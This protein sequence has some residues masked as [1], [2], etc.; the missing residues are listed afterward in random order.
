M[1]GHDF[2]YNSEVQEVTPE[3][4]WSVCSDGMKNPGAVRGAV[5]DFTNEMGLVL[6]VEFKA[7]HSWKSWMVQKPSK[8]HC[9]TS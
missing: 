6:T 7:G 9:V 1:A 5:E 8:V 2:L 4:D 3:Q